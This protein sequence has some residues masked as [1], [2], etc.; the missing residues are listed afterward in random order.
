MYVLYANRQQG[1]REKKVRRE[2]FEPANFD[3]VGTVGCGI[4]LGDETGYSMIIVCYSTINY[5]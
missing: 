5:L 4:L 3:A 2:G 1:M